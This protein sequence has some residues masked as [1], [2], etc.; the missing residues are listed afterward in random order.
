MFAH[1]RRL[2]PEQT[3]DSDG[4]AREQCRLVVGFSHEQSAD[5]A[6]DRRGRRRLPAVGERFGPFRL[7][8]LL[9][10]GA[11]GKVFLARQSTLAD[12]YVGR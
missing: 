10:Q 12:R 11:F 2:A 9:G 1:G 7:A 5:A 8:A 4:P 3:D 6:A